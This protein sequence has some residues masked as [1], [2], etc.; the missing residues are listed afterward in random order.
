[1]EF[2]ES[3]KERGNNAQNNPGGFGGQPVNP[4]DI[5]F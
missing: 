5:P 1:M 4:D 2:M 3:K